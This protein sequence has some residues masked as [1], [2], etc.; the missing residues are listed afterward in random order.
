MVEASGGRIGD[1]RFLAVFEVGLSSSA[2]S[3]GGIHWE[4][5]LRREER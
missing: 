1:V 4:A 3:G 5:G 2:D